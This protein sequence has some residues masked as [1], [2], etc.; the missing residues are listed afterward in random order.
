MW[1][2]G[3]KLDGLAIYGVPS[4]WIG[5][6]AK[7]LAYLSATVVVVDIVGPK[8]IRDWGAKIRSASSIV[9]WTVNGFGLLTVFAGLVVQY[10]GGDSAPIL[11]LLGFGVLLAYQGRRIVALFGRLLDRPGLSTWTSSIALGV[12]TVSFLAD[13]I[14][15]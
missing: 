2:S 4:V 6:L 8:R 3:Q 5:R 13:M 12:L 1:W 11:L 7:A 15:S 14:T 9:E 10:S